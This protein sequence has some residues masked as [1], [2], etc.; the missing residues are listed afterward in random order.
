MKRR[1]V[2]LSNDAN[3]KCSRSTPVGRESLS[4]RLNEEVVAGAKILSGGEQAIDLIS[5]GKNLSNHCIASC[6]FTHRSPHEDA[7]GGR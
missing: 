2:I 1:V 4:F 5:Q 3:R 7:G 6:E